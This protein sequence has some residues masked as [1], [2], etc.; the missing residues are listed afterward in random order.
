MNAKH[1][2]TK[3]KDK[4]TVSLE[5]ITPIN[6]RLVQVSDS[7]GTP[8]VIW[9]F[10]F[11]DLMSALDAFYRVI[12]VYACE[13]WIVKDAKAGESTYPELLAISSKGNHPPEV[14]E[15]D[16]WNANRYRV[17]TFSE[18]GDEPDWEDEEYWEDEDDWASD[19]YQAQ[20]TVNEHVRRV[21]G[22]EFGQPC[23]C[24]LNS[25]Y[26]EPDP[27]C[28]GCGGTGYHE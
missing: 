2:L 27:D 22:E 21:L 13:G 17:G 18:E 7:E 8:V 14:P 4:V 1:T 15:A 23:D 26:N 25:K 6:D 11:G 5:I 24:V 20:P 10:H 19:D 9:R 16:Y 28:E 12:G 3:G